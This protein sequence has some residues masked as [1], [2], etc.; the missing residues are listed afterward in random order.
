[1]KNN[2]YISKGLKC[3]KIAFTLIE[4]LTVVAIIGIL[5]AILIPAL[6]GVRERARETVKRSAYRQF[7]IANNMYA[8]DNKG[9]TCLVA[10]YRGGDQMQW[11]YLLSPY[12]AKEYQDKWKARE[13]AIFVD[14]F[15]ESPNPDNKSWTG[16]GLNSYVRKPDDN[17]QNAFWN[18]EQKNWQKET[19][20][21]AITY[22]ERRIFL[23]DIKTGT[24]L[25]AD[26]I[27]TTRHE[28][29]GMFV[30][31]DG[32]VVLYDADEADLAFN[33]PSARRSR[34]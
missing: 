14:S 16:V 20:L 18:D 28:G 31:F 1:M 26:Q 30:L 3:G 22:P 10:D 2:F 34:N 23:G 11:H 12:I 33:D 27:D 21:G 32:S 29:K 5:A 25:V 4:L 24:S 8:T 9:M 7:F 19:L 17:K 6:G 15:Y 13:D